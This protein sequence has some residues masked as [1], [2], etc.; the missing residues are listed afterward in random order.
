[1]VGWT[2]IFCPNELKNR[3]CGRFGWVGGWL[4]NLG[5][6]LISTQVVVD[7]GLGNSS[8]DMSCSYSLGLIFIILFLIDDGWTG[9]IE[10]NA[11]SA[12]KCS[13]C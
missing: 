9:R 11:I 7:V 5:V 8:Y 2:Y 6:M 12:L 3:Y 10:Y 13:C 4:D 1:M